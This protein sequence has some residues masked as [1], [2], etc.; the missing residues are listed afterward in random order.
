MLWFSPHIIRRSRVYIESN[1][2]ACID[3]STAHNIDAKTQ[4]TS[5]GRRRSGCCVKDVSRAHTHTQKKENDRP[6][7]HE[8]T[9]DATTTTLNW[10]SYQSNKNPF[11]VLLYGADHFRVPGRSCRGHTCVRVR[12][13]CVIR[14]QTHGYNTRTG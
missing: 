7:C 2:Y 4:S 9:H 5:A 11:R 13:S 8:R 12:M 1:R 3:A 6:H 10:R 14:Q